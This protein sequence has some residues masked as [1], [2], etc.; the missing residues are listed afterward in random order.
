[1]FADE[2]LKN[3]ITFFLRCF[4]LSRSNNIPDLNYVCN[5]RQQQTRPVSVFSFIFKQHKIFIK[6]TKNVFLRLQSCGCLC[7]SLFLLTFILGCFSQYACTRRE[8]ENKKKDLQ[9][10]RKE[11]GKKKAKLEFMMQTLI[12]LTLVKYQHGL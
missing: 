10:A 5:L 12:T 9:L 7:C 4:T 8:E 11:E 6:N 2:K 3:K 1:M